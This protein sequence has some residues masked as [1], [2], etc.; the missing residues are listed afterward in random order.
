MKRQITLP[1]C[2]KQFSLSSRS[3]QSILQVQ[4]PRLRRVEFTTAATKKHE[5]FQ[6]LPS[7]ERN[8]EAEDAVFTSQVQGLKQWWSSPRFAGLKRPY[9]AEDVASKQ[10][11]L[12]QT[13]PS[14]TMAR[15]LF[16]LLNEKAEKGLPLHTSKTFFIIFHL[17]QTLLLIKK[18]SFHSGCNRSRT[19]D[20]ASSISR[21]TVRI[22]LGMLFHPNHYQRSLA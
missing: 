18:S 14:S 6:F 3:H 5:S 15:K 2:S 22:R 8:G 4:N 11:S 21:S 19:N 7:V 13:Y 9:S 1:T 10:G 16:N 17:A 12:Q 20:T